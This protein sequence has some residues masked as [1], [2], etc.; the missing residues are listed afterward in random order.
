MLCIQGVQQPAEGGKSWASGSDERGTGELV[1]HAAGHLGDLL[2][3]LG[4]G[5]EVR[6]N[7]KTLSQVS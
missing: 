2:V 4:E 7:K 3:P 5:G 1:G 6:L